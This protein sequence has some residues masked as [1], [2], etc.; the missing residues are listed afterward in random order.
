VAELVTEAGRERVVSEDELEH[1]RLVLDEAR[2]DRAI[3]RATARGGAEIPDLAR[4]REAVRQARRAVT[5][6]L[7]RAV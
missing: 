1:A 3:R 7:E 6:R 5:G 2:L 4:E